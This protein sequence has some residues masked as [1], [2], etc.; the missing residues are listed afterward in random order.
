MSIDNKMPLLVVEDQEFPLE[1]I[2]T[3]LRVV[4]PSV[5]Y[6]VAT[7]Y[8]QAEALIQSKVYE[9]VLLDNRIPKDADSNYLEEIGYGLIPS[10]RENS[11]DAVII[12]TSTS[13][14]AIL[15]RLPNPDYLFE[16]IQKYMK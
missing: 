3:R 6:D 2:K 9:V 13:N 14:P 10:I 4:F 8:N 1:C 5:A 11:P 16:V 7:C 15:R 12:G